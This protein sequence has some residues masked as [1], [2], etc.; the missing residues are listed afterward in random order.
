MKIP[1]G[2]FFWMNRGRS[3]PYAEAGD[4]QRGLCG[5]PSRGLWL[6][7]QQKRNVWISVGYG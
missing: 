1:E 4:D 5:G 2:V 3:S 6:R 7:W